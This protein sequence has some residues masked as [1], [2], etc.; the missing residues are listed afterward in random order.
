MTEHVSTL[1]EL[2]GFIL[3]AIGLWLAWPPL[4]L[5]GGGSALIAAGY[6]LDAE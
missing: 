2:V 6:L 4:A 3:A 5:V 1:L